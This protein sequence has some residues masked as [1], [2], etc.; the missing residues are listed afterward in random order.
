MTDKKNPKVIHIIGNGDS[1]DF[2][3]NK[4]GIKI[5]CNLPPFEISG[6]HAC[7]I[8]DFKMMKAL[9]DGSVV[10]PFDW[11]LGM[12]PK[13]WMEMN[14]SFYMKHAAQIKEFYLEK[15]GYASNYTD[16]NCGHVAT[17]YAANKLK[18]NEIHLYGFDSLF[19]ANTR[20][21]T[22]FILASDRGAENT[23]RLLD[24]WRGIWF[25][26][27][28]EFPETKFVLYHKNGQLKFEQGDNVEIV[29][30]K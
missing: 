24:R 21:R 27:F 28:K 5:A 20:S 9:T 3:K 11:V 29:T 12:R 25:H 8:V 4:P 2:Y 6:L 17:H 26:M 1:V 15:P 23:N 22:D 18:G 7:V 19:E 16:F 14:P 13:K 30:E 10:I